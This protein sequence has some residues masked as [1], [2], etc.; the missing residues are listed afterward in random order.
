MDDHAVTAVLGGTSH[1]YFNGISN[2]FVNADC[3]LL[4]IVSVRVGMRCLKDLLNREVSAFLGHGHQVVKHLLSLSLAVII[5]CL[6]VLLGVKED[7]FK[8]LND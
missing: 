4:S 1:V 3:F 6:L 5:N 8:T 2:G 7:Q